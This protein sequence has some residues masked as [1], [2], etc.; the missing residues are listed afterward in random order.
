V[1][2]KGV[3]ARNSGRLTGVTDAE[4]STGNWMS[5]SAITKVELTTTGNFLTGTI[6]TL[7]A[8]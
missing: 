8:E 5:T 6:A 2:Y 4:L 3:I 7:I 1:F